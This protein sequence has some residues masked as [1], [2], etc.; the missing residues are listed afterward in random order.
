M[1]EP[2]PPGRLA[3]GGR[4]TATLGQGRRARPCETVR[5]TKAEAFDACQLLAD[6]D[7]C[8][9]RAG[10]PE[11]ATALAELFD[12]IESRLCEGE[13]GSGSR[14]GAIAGTGTG[15][16]PVGRPSL[17]GQDVEGDSASGL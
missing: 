14:I 13:P 10:Y 8:L 1:R 17:A 7:G 4:T 6:A 9:V 16:A 12:L 5:L 2:L 3:A 11:E 15:D